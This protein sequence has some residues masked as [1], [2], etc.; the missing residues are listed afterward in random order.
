MITRP[1]RAPHRRSDSENPLYG[2][3]RGG[4]DCIS[5]LPHYLIIQFAFQRYF[6]TP[7]F[8]SFV[9]PNPSLRAFFACSICP[10]N[11][12]PPRSHDKLLSQPAPEALG[13]PQPITGRNA[14]AWAFKHATLSSEQ[15]ITT[16]GQRGGGLERVGSVVF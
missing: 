8:P 2:A 6:A 4:P 9:V 14:S 1:A 13:L 11:E 12:A 5:L 7:Y 16:E 10:A 3:F 15:K